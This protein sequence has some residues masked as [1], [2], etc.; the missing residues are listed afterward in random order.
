MILTSLLIAL[1]ITLCFAIVVRQGNDVFVYVNE[2]QDLFLAA[3]QRVKFALC[4]RA[5]G[6]SHLMGEASLDLMRHLPGGKAALIGMTYKHIRN[7]TFPAM[8]KAWRVGWG[9]EEYDFETGEG[10]YVKWRRPPKA[11]ERNML[12]PPNEWDQI[13]SFPNGFHFELASLLDIERHR[14]SSF[15]AVMIDEIAK[16]K[17]EAFD[18]VISSA[19]R[20][21]EHHQPFIWMDWDEENPQVD[22]T[23]PNHYFQAVYMFT[24]IPWLPSGQWIFRFEKLAATYPDE[25]YW[26]EGNVW[27][28]VHILTEKWIRRQFK[29]MG[30]EMSIKVQVELLNKRISQLPNSWYYAFS[31]DKHI[32][33]AESVRRYYSQERFGF[34]VGEI[35]DLVGLIGETDDLAPL[36][37]ELLESLR[38][39]ADEVGAEWW[40]VHPD[41]PL[42][43]TFDFNAALNSCTVWQENTD[44]HKVISQKGFYVQGKSFS[45]VVDQIDAYFADH[46]TKEIIVYGDRNGNKVGANNEPSFF[47][48]IVSRFDSKGWSAVLES[49]GGV[50]NTQDHEARYNISNECLKGDNPAIPDIWMHEAPNKYLIISIQNTPRKKGAGFKK[51]KS[52]ENTED[53]K[54]RLRATDWGDG[55]DY[56]LRDKYGGMVGGGEGEEM[57]MIVMR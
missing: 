41:L 6:K 29:Q 22:G 10:D 39:K 20:G 2:K 46:P 31:E 27:H 13:I 36:D 47:E 12:M 35:E 54:L 55:L 40:L 32:K 44:L 49:E 14:G 16:C 38:E 34:D 21:N 4:S 24:S 42:E 53:E 23:V 28:N 26:M 50:G 18:D 17:Q 15:D 37:Y 57:P 7:K 48:Q 3:T 1:L 43:L 11:W 56:Y 8:E 30:G 5:F 19:M 45:E 33:S 52:S 51:D 25:Y 9:L